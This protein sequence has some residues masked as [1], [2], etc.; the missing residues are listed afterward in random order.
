MFKLHGNWTEVVFDIYLCTVA[1]W[2]RAHYSWYSG[3]KIVPTI[4]LK[5]YEFT[6]VRVHIDFKCFTSKTYE[7]QR[8]LN[9]TDRQSSLVYHVLWF[10]YGRRNKWTWTKLAF[11]AILCIHAFDVVDFIAFCRRINNQM[12]FDS[13]NDTIYLIFII[14]IARK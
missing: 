12:M 9:L 13:F 3:L 2:T 10:Q 1:I 5:F 8:L 4:I 11:E 6:V 7:L 14:L